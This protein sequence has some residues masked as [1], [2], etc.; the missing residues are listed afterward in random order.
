[1]TGLKRK[2]VGLAVVTLCVLC[3][4]AVWGAESSL[5]SLQRLPLQETYQPGFGGVVGYVVS[6]DGGAY[7]VHE[8]GENRYAAVKGRPVFKGDTL[9]TEADGRLVF[10]LND[11]SRM[12][13]S[14]E[15]AIAITRSVYS[16]ENGSRTSFLNMITGKVRFT[17]RKMAEF[18]H[19][20]FNVKTKSSVVGVRG[21]DFI[22]TE[23]LTSSQIVTLRNTLLEIISLEDPSAAAILMTAFQ[24]LGI[25]VGELGGI[26]ENITEEQAQQMLQDV[27]GGGPLNGETG[28]EG[29]QQG[30]G[31]YHVDPNVA[32]AGGW[33][34]AFFDVFADIIAELLNADD[35]DQ[36]IENIM[37]EL[38]AVEEQIQEDEMS[39]LPF[40][41][42][43][44]DRYVPESEEEGGEE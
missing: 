30:G 24:Q 27:F 11:G 25:D 31:E 17:V 3:A 14:A 1:M 32:G 12:T 5:D 21:S 36:A 42:E 38:D 39:L 9:F 7:I 18:Q 26:P 19:N 28:D 34:A 16:P 40:M 22:I 8:G 4:G 10:D 41:P 43:P 23:T 15:T 35:I 2:I 33:D 29:G 44:P 13:V 37:D 6:V 20:R